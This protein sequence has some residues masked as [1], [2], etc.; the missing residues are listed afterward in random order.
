MKVKMEGFHKLHDDLEKVIEKEDSNS[1]VTTDSDETKQE[2]RTIRERV[3]HLINTNIFQIGIIC[4]VFLD[5][6]L[7]I[8]ELLLDLQI[9]QVHDYDKMAVAF[10]LRYASL[11]ILGIFLLEIALRLYALRLDFFRHKMEMFDAVVVIASFVLDIVFRQHDGPENGVG[12]LIVLRLWR[13][14]RILNG[15]IMSV[16]KQADKKLQ[17]ERR[18]REACEQELSKF[19]EYC[20]AQEGEIELLQG[21]LRKHG[22]TDADKHEQPPSVST[23]AVIAE[24]NPVEHQILN[25]N[26]NG[27]NISQNL[28]SN[29]T[30][31]TTAATTT[32]ATVATTITTTT[33]AATTTTTTATTA[34]NIL[35][36]SISSTDN[37]RS[38]S[39]TSVSTCILTPAMTTPP[40]PPHPIQT[41]TTLDKTATANFSQ[42]K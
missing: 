29:T 19:R 4:L 24:V 3:I 23:I 15:I 8:S 20:S 10:I 32:S 40:T 9:L 39:R 37:G 26:N 27:S 7:V 36:S 25:S 6:L 22:I 28:S 11:A 17:R 18:L 21:L 13:M 30:I 31:T 2:F 1:S 5:C 33:T 14:T 35:I 41:T 12:L 16:K 42:T 38:P 34:P